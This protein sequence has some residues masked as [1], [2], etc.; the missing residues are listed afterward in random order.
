MIQTKPSHEYENGFLR[1]MFGAFEELQA[2][3]DRMRMEDSWAERRDRIDKV[4]DHIVDN[5]MDVYT[6]ARLR[7]SARD[8]LNK[9]GHRDIHV[10]DIAELAEL[11]SHLLGY[12]PKQHEEEIRKFKAAQYEKDPEVRA[13][14]DE[15]RDLDV[16]E[17]HKKGRWWQYPLALGFSKISGEELDTRTLT[18][19]LESIIALA[20][21]IRERDDM[22]DSLSSRMYSYQLSI[23]SH[24]WNQVYTPDEVFKYSETGDHVMQGREAPPPFEID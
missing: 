15:L 5:K 10:E 24:N 1:S 14:L 17:S 3:L 22:D 8:V 7:S 12:D 11:N 20:D 21:E 13:K 23:N 4:L 18:E 2:G 19:R 9:L 16:G 6:P